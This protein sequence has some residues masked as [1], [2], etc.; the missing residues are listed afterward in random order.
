MG[1]VEEKKDNE[2]PDG[3]TPWLAAADAVPVLEFAVSAGVIASRFPHVLFVI[4]AACSI[5]AGFG[6]VL[7]KIFLAC[8]KKNI[9]WLNKQ[10]RFMM[11]GGFLLMIISVIANIRSIS[12]RTVFLRIFRLPAVIFFA[13]GVVGMVLMSVFGKKLDQTNVAH[14]WIEQVTNIAAQGMFMIGILVW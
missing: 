5:F 4:G 6:K 11:G 1:N 13:L 2:I 14:N 3:F 8:R 7:W 10:F 12:F 9:L